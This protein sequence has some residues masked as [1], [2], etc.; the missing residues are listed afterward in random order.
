LFLDDFEAGQ[1]WNVT[2]QTITAEQIKAF[3]AVYDPLPLHL[4]EEY[5]KTTRYGSLIASGPM[6]FLT[7]WSEF[8][9][10]V[11]PF[12]D[13]LVGGINNHVSFL[14]PVRPGDTLTGEIRVLGTTPRNPHNGTVEFELDA[15]NQDDLPVIH[16]V[17]QV[18]IAR[19]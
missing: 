11:D 17:V 19:K 16:A 13:Q 6:S 2:T 5:A 14:A 12:G 15:Y 18:V 9:R 7:V 3:A 1:T 10:E 4:D 8:I